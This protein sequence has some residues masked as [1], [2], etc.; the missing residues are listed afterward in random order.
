MAARPKI[1][2]TA[3]PPITP[4]VMVPIVLGDESALTP[5]LSPPLELPLFDVAAAKSVFAFAWEDCAVVRDA[6]V[7]EDGCAELAVDVFTE[8]GFEDPPD[9]FETLF[10]LVGVAWA[11][12][13]AR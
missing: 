5:S 11:V 3:I 1:H 4:P 7:H 2:S 13:D 6:I 12:G 8:A 10:V 9:V